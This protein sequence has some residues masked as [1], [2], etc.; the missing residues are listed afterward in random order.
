MSSTRLDRAD[1]PSLSSR[2]RREII[3]C[4][5]LAIALSFLWIWPQVIN[6]RQV[7]DRGDPIFSAWRLAR[8]AHQLSNDPLHLYDGNIFH[9]RR[10][11]LAYSDATLLQGVL[12]APFIAAGIEPLLVANALLV[13]SFP[14]CAL[15]FFY[16]GWRLTGAAHVGLVAG[17]LGAW[18]PFHAE[19]FSHLE[20]QW[21]MFAPLAIVGV[22]ETAVHPTWWRGCLVGLLVAL[23]SL[24]SMYLGLM[25]AT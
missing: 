4:G 10:W 7:P 9:P 2:R 20:L 8:V 25:L 18:H 17:V 1:E 5:A 11:T 21:F 24:A 3:V 13:V 23:Q 22:L 19:H 15:A 6:L 14:L 16:S 12:A